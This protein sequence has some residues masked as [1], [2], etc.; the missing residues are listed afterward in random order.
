MPSAWPAVA[1]LLAATA[2]ACT[3]AR[4]VSAD[5]VA[6]AA[7]PLV[8]ATPDVA[9]PF[10]VALLQDGF[11]YCTGTLVTADVVVT[12]AHCIDFAHPD[13]VFVGSHV[14]QDGYT[15]AVESDRRH[16]QY[17]QRTLEHDIAVLKL[18]T[19]C[20]VTPAPI[21]TRPLDD[22]F[23]G[24]HVRLVGFGKTAPIGSAAEAGEPTNRAKREGTAT[25]DAIDDTTFETRPSP[26]QPCSRDSGGPALVTVDGVE[27]LAG[28]VSYG[29]FGCAQYTRF[30]R[31]DRYRDFLAPYVEPP[32]L[33]SGGCTVTPAPRMSTSALAAAIAL[34]SASIGV[35]R[36]RAQRAQ[37]RAAPARESH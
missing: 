12:A 20:S 7:S 36:A 4:D 29:D 21:L 23:L 17:Q 27:Y 3:N 25:L 1:V 31:I 14:G 6:S 26:S 30:S 24:A 19:S 33:A 5:V 8:N 34:M 13:A 18:A 35:T 37:L 32:L 11:P 10:V 9:D 16:P 28:T 22:S 2:S 15:I